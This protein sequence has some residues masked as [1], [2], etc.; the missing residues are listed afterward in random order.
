MPF[1]WALFDMQ[2]SRFVLTATQMDGVFGSVTI[3]PD[4]MQIMNPILILAFLPLFQVSRK[5]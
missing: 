2:G 5:P 3:K 4:Q 1:F